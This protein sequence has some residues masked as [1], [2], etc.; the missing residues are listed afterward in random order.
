MGAIL[1]AGRPSHLQL[2]VYFLQSLSQAF[3]SVVKSWRVKVVTV[4]KKQV[5]KLKK[6]DCMYISSNLQRIG[7][8]PGYIELAV[9]YFNDF[10]GNIILKT[11][12]MIYKMGNYCRT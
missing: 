4:A 2:H 11:V 10:K 12:M 3:T 8:N 6:G 1:K 9:K 7:I 5:I